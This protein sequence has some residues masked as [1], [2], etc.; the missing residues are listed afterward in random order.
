[1]SGPPTMLDAALA[2]AF[3]GLAVFPLTPRDKVPAIPKAEGGQGF[4]DATKD[5]AVIHGWWTRWP[6][7]NVGIAT[8]AASGLVVLDVDGPEGKAS[9]ATLCNGEG[10]PLTPTART[11][12]GQHLLFAHPDGP[13]AAR[14][15]CDPAWT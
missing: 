6:D 8:G 10:P 9:F 4:K 12:R 7:A 1:M 14:P 13:L 15:G 11:G 2:Y 3:Q 5:A